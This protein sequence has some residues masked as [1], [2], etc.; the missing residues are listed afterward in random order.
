MSSKDKEKIGF[1]QHNIPW[2]VDPPLLLE[3]LKRLNFGNNTVNWVQS[4]MSNRSQK[5]QVGG[6]LS[7]SRPIEL[8]VPQGSI[9]G[10]QLFLLYESDFEN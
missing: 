10:P 8:E 3:K 9:L 2:I 1:P 4:F 5:V 7:S 6:S